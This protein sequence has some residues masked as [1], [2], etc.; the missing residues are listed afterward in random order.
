MKKKIDQ[1]VWT[2][3]IAAATATASCVVSAAPPASA[4]GPSVPTT[5][6]D[7]GRFKGPQ[8]LARADLIA[9]LAPGGSNPL[10]RIK[11]IGNKSAPATLAKVTCYVNGNS[12]TGAPCQPQLH[13]V[14]LPGV[15]LPPGTS[16]S[17]P[18]VWRVP[19]G[20]LDAIT[21]FTTFGLNIRSAPGLPAS[22]LKFTVCADAGETVVESN[23]SNNCYTFSYSWP[24]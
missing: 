2:A 23:E 19:I 17:A 21:G 15:V 4:A 8:P 13:Y 16:M 20:G 12:A 9:D 11:N 22:G 7:A 6:A 18:N 3:L 24:N 1:C 14:D 5:A 10:F